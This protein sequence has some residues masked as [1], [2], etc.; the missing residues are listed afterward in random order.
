MG[1]HS[2]TNTG[3]GGQQKTEP[4][5]RALVWRGQ[6]GTDTIIW[7]VQQANQGTAQIFLKQNP[8]RLP[9][10]KLGQDKGLGMVRLDAGPGQ[11]SEA[12]LG[13][14][15]AV[16]FGVQLFPSVPVSLSAK[17]GLE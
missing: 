17:Q 3:Q 13:S 8:P 1:A 11:G 5:R 10:D 12:T 6:H 4:P 14:V 2:N 16:C 15:S 9:C 7:D